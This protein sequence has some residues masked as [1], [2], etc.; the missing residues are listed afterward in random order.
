MFDFGT[1]LDATTFIKVGDFAQF[2]AVVSLCAGVLYL[3]YRRVS[4]R[5]P[6]EAEFASTIFVL[7]VAI[8]LLV[9][10][11]KHAPAISFG[12]FGA[13]SI[14]RFRAQ[15]KRPQRMIFIFMAAAIGVC[16]GAGEFVTTI[17]GTAALSVLTLI[18]FGLSPPV[19]KSKS[20]AL[21]PATADSGAAAPL[22]ERIWGVDFVPATLQDG[23]HIRILVVVD[24]TSRRTLAAIPEMYFSGSGLAG[25]ID[26]L[27]AAHGKPTGLVSETWPEF[28]SRAFLDWK[29][30]SAIGW[31][32]IAPN[33]KPELAIFA[34]SERVR[35]ECAGRRFQT[36][37][38]ARADLEAWRDDYNAR[39]IPAVTPGGVASFTRIPSSDRPAL[40][41]RAEI[42]AGESIAS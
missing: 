7:T 39:L 37:L 13:M 3:V 23:K 9:S 26:R 24:E 29:Q 18:S 4:P 36:L 27:I 35:D 15:I 33:S 25:E 14:V 38:Q 8:G 41:P 11:I 30:A 42:V 2:L 32:G 12:L 1:T 19:A 22:A 20:K 10:I 16:C 17:L 28:G 34:F 6:D 21:A 40:Q 5:E 31:Q